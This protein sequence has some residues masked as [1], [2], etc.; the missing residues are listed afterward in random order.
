MPHLR[1]VWRGI[2]VLE[3]QNYDI[4]CPHISIWLHPC[5][6]LLTEIQNAAKHLNISWI[7]P[8]Q[9]KL[10]CLDAV[11]LRGKNLR[12]GDARA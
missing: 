12:G 3:I 5:T 1:T 8:M 6:I 2:R 7:F 11:F 10:I 4:I 9:N